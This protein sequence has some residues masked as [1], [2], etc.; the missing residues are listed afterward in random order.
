MVCHR[1]RC[2]LEVFVDGKFDL[3]AIVLSCWTV[4]CTKVIDAVYLAAADE[5]VYELFAVS[6]LEYVGRLHW[7][8]SS[9]LETVDL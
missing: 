3:I 7:L 5:H 8:A 2:L 6:L 1:D 9:A 4:H